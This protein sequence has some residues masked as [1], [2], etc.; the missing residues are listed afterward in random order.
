MSSRQA[1]EKQQIYGALFGAPSLSIAEPATGARRIKS[2][3]SP[4]VK[5]ND[6]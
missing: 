1:P 2:R 6:S 5:Y 3:L 4:E